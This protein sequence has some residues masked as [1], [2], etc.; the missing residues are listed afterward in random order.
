M[1]QMNHAKRNLLSPGKRREPGIARRG[2]TL[3]II[4]GIDSLAERN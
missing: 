1:E 4:E 2:H 3:S